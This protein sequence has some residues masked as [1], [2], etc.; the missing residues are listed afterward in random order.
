MVLSTALETIEQSKLEDL[1]TRVLS[2]SLFTKE[3]EYSV[4][5]VH[6]GT[7]FKDAV[8]VEDLVRIDEGRFFTLPTDFEKI[9]L[10]IQS[11]LDLTVPEMI[12]LV[13]HT[14]K[15]EYALDP[16]NLELTYRVSVAGKRTIK[17]ART[18]TAA[19]TDSET[20]RA[21]LSTILN[22]L[23]K[24]R[25]FG[26][27]PEESKPILYTLIDFSG[28]FPELFHTAIVTKEF[29]PVSVSKPRRERRGLYEELLEKYPPHAF[30]PRIRFSPT[31]IDHHSILKRSKEFEFNLPL[32][33][34]FLE[35]WDYEGV[36]FQRPIWPFSLTLELDR[37]TYPSE[38][39]KYRGGSLNLTSNLTLKSLG[40]GKYV[41]RPR[42]LTSS[43][44][45]LLLN[46]QAEEKVIPSIRRAI[47]DSS[48]HSPSVLILS[49]QDHYASHL[50]LLNDFLV[51]NCDCPRHYVFW[52]NLIPAFGQKLK[53][54]L[55]QTPGYESFQPTIF[56]SGPYRKIWVPGYYY[57][58]LDKKT[59][60]L[61][62]LSVYIDRLL[63][64]TTLFGAAKT[65]EEAQRKS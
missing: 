64:T 50:K 38:E 30:R 35:W 37:T 4:R 23:E 48:Y 55:L 19:E 42:G 53:E 26:T 33:E 11:Q 44:L 47:A 15:L 36:C 45:F 40:K 8:R 17:T 59:G 14:F 10:E 43:D 49:D 34:Y 46:P 62:V 2:A 56:S 60:L 5:Q 39:L 63:E 1:A 16:V 29:E 21:S 20:D 6:S 9:D 61:D 27:N 18:L 51:N 32:L 58:N 41:G 24:Q 52:Q 13:N 7:D 28:G 57:S 25:L 54:T 22:F 31:E 65:W 12:Q 3:G